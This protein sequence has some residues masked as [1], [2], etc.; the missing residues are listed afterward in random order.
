MISYAFHR[1]DFSGKKGIKL[2]F[3]ILYI[4]NIKLSLISIIEYISTNSA[5][6]SLQ[7]GNDVKWFNQFLTDF[8]RAFPDSAIQK[9]HVV[10][11]DDL[12]SSHFR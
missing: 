10:A 5:E 3:K 12:N 1:S 2:F 6:S 7:V 4:Y 8:F 11:Q 9:E